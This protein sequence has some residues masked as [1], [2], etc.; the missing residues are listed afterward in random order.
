[1]REKKR[2]IALSFVLLLASLLLLTVAIIATDEDSFVV[3]NLTVLDVPYDDGS[4]L[5]L[6]WVPL[7]KEKRIIEY[8]VYRGLSPDSL[9]FLG[10]IPVNVKTGVSSDTLYYYDKDYQP[11]AGIESRS[12]AKLKREKHVPANSP[13]YQQLPR[14]LQV[15]A[16]MASRFNMLAYVGRIKDFYYHS[17]KTRSTDP[18]DSTAYAGLKMNQLTLLASLKAGQKYYYTVVAVDEKRNFHKMATP[19]FGVPEENAPEKPATFASVYVQ[20]AKRL[21][22]EWENPLYADDLAQFSIYYMSAGA[23]ATFNPAS[24]AP[25][26]KPGIPIYMGNANGMTQLALQMQDGVLTDVVS[27]K[28]FPAPAINPTQASFVLGITDYAGNESFSTASLP[29]LANAAQLPD[30]P[31]F[32]VIDKPGDKGDYLSIVWGKPTVYITQATILDPKTQKMRI[33]YALSTNDDFAVKNVYFTVASK[34]GKQV[35][36]QINEFYQDNIIKLVIPKNYDVKKGL[37]VT[38]HMKANPELGK[39]YQFTQSLS[40]DEQTKSLLPDK[41]MLK[42]REVKAFSYSIYK[43]KPVDPKYTFSKKVGGD[44]STIDDNVGYEKTIYKPVAM[45]D[46]KK[47]LVLV[48]SNIDLTYD[49]KAQATVQTSIYADEAAKALDSKKKDIQS[50]IDKYKAM[51]A[52]A[53]PGMKAQLTGAIDQMQKMLDSMNNA[54]L[55]KAN[56]IKGNSARMHYIAKVRTATRRSI[57]YVLVT[58]D[59]NGMFTISDMRD[60]DN[61]LQFTSPISNWF[62]TK[63]LPMIIATLLFGI[64]VFIMIQKAKLGH[65]LYIRP[66]AGIQ[67]IDNAVGRA[68]EMGR[69]ILFVPG[70]SG[71]SDIAT[72]AGLA[73]LGQVA[74]KAAEYDTRILVPCRD[75]LVMPIAQEIVREAHYEA[76]RPDTFDKSSVFYLT[77]AQFAF[78]AGVN[79]VMIREKAATN[80]FMGMFYAEALIMTETGNATGAIQI[81]GTDAVTQIPFF[82]TTCD[83]T[84]IGEELYAASAYLKHEPLMLGTLKAQDYFKFLLMFIVIVGTILSTAHITF[85]INVFPEK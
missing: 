58:S 76:G 15:L 12:P 77:D 8:R 48:D 32:K 34:D 64:M 44:Q 28:K 3:K 67:E 23:A 53:D 70:L 62:D 25:G 33:N 43:K 39:D 40:F 10:S 11:F 47:K 31:V 56:S 65:D 20:D 45:I 81:A 74:K 2:K 83:Y 66:I 26:Q 22:F 42:G 54:E 19:K 46:S 84:L 17:E 52:T 63:K 18:K 79:G 24:M 30:K 55:A 61:N 29:K 82:I 16:P 6:S 85:L 9:F 49:T 80:F 36:K 38:M 78:V 57:N 73:I 75:Y 7:S 1:M 69:P 50:N 21:Q 27:G 72:L 35:F 5:Q 14:D 60:K 51:M 59:G 41:L 71:I 4:G 37:L 68:T 13:L